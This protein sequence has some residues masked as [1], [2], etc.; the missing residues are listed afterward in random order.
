MK[1]KS[2]KELVKSL[3]LSK[4]ELKKFAPL[5]QE[6]LKRELMNEIYYSKIR[7]NLLKINENIKHYEIKKYFDE[8]LGTSKT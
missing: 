5:I 8:T 1:A 2:V 6:S 7:N 4:D 3:N